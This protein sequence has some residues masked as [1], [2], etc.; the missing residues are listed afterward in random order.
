[1]TSMT[2]APQPMSAAHLKP[3]R[4]PSFMIVRLIGPT[5]M[6]SN[7]PL[8][9][10]VSAASKIGGPFSM[11]RRPGP[12]FILV[13]LFDLAPHLTRNARPDDPI[14]QISGEEGGQH[15]IKNRVPQ[16][17]NQAQEQSGDDRLGEGAGRAQAERFE[18]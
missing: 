14:Q 11:S 16:N 3:R 12:A 13:L 7:S 15:I 9:K 10:P 5:G 17:H 18:A 8:T 4:A 6:E 1:M 2:V